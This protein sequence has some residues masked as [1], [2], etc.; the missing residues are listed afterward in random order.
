M[1]HPSS[2]LLF[3]GEGFGDWNP[4][5]NVDNDNTHCQ[6]LCWVNAVIVAHTPLSVVAAEGDLTVVFSDK[7]SPHEARREGFPKEMNC[8]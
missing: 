5:L 1:A 8:L 4:F 6:G 3:V 2:S 7:E